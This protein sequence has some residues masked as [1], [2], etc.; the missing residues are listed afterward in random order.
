VSTVNV[1]NAATSANSIYNTPML[2][3][4]TSIPNTPILTSSN[5]ISNTAMLSSK[6]NNALIV[7]DNSTHK[8]FISRTKNIFRV[9]MLEFLNKNCLD[10]ISGIP[11]SKP[12]PCICNCCTV[13]NSLPIKK[14]AVYNLFFTSSEDLCL[15]NLNSDMNSPNVQVADYSISATN[16]CNVNKSNTLSKFKKILFNT[17]SP[18]NIWINEL[19]S[20]IIKNENASERCIVTDKNASKKLNPMQ[21]VINKVHKATQHIK[22]HFSLCNKCK[23]SKLSQSYSC[24]CYSNYYKHKYDKY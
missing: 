11:L 8:D 18:K 20:L 3:S 23:K 17:D 9:Q 10:G 4:N 13:V 19:T 5:S 7:S 24:K 22:S 14:S 6:N 2:T 16:D 1:S 12:Y 21:N 15:T